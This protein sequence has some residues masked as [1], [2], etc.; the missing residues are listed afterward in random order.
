MHVL[1]G[2]GGELL[3]PLGPLCGDEDCECNRSLAAL[4]SSFLAESITVADHDVTL[5]DLAAKCTQ[6]LHRTGWAESLGPDDTAE[7]ARRRHGHFASIA[8]GPCRFVGTQ[9]PRIRQESAKAAIRLYVC[10]VKTPRPKTTPRTRRSSDQG[11][12][13][14]SG[15]PS[16][17]WTYTT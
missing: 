12:G 6:L 4:D 2:R 3:A 16:D 13:K 9:A 15:L 8:H 5:D 7:L 17:R 14:S 11:T 1:T 10:G